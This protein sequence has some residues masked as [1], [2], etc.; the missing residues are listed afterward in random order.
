MFYIRYFEIKQEKKEIVYE[1]NIIGILSPNDIKTAAKGENLKTVIFENCFQGDIED[2][3][4]KAFGNNV[5]VVGWKGTTTTETKS[6]NG[7]GMWGKQIYT[8]RGYMRKT[9]WGE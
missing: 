8:L 1:N 9:L 7:W 6:F 4:E 5:D 3:W 2:K